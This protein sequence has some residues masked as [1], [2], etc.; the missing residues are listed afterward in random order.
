MLRLICHP[1]IKSSLQSLQAELA[2]AQ[3]EKQSLLAQ[4][5]ETQ[6]H[7]QK[8]G[9]LNCPSTTSDQTPGSDV[10]LNRVDA[11]PPKVP[12]AQSNSSKQPPLRSLSWGSS[13][14]ISAKQQ[15]PPRRSSFNTSHDLIHAENPASELLAKQHSAHQ[16]LI[17]R[18]LS[19]EPSQSSAASDA[20]D[21]E[22]V[23]QD[24]LQEVLQAV[25]ARKGSVPLLQLDKLTVKVTLF[26]SFVNCVAPTV[27][28]GS[29]FHQINGC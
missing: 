2:A 21:I 13:S 1:L 19:Y 8:A 22:A 7:L 4:T 18:W 29:V 5:A 14:K 28:V 26:W 24:V 20:A 23:R 15:P 17:Q 11:L 10:P 25:T 16:A 27:S 9:W 12:L 3:L 6:A